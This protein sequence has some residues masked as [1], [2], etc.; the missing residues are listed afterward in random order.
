MGSNSYFYNCN[1]GSMPFLL[2]NMDISHQICTYYTCKEMESL[3]ATGLHRLWWEP[4]FRLRCNWSFKV[5]DQDLWYF[6]EL[7]YTKCMLEDTIAKYAALWH[8]M[9]EDI[10]PDWGRTFSRGISSVWKNGNTWLSY[11]DVKTSNK[12][13]FEDIK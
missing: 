12:I 2:I 1:I 7:H 4:G 11:F 3:R 13:P 5:L 9:L 6:R 8:L 10:A